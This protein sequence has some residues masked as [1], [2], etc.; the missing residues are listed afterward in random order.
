VF[1]GADEAVGE[2]L[3][4]SEDI[5][6]SANNITDLLSGEQVGSE[7]GYNVGIL[8]SQFSRPHPSGISSRPFCNAHHHRS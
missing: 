4:V 5:L 8:V 6:I 2:G 3:R 7:F 1:V